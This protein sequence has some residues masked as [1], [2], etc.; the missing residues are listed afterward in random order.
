[1]II[2]NIINCIV[3]PKKEDNIER[4][5]IGLCSSEMDSRENQQNIE[6][7]KLNNLYSS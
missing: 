6:L 7:E 2:V 5:R 4:N 3:D 1:V